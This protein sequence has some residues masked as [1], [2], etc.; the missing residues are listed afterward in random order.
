[1]YQNKRFF[2]ISPI[3]IALVFIIGLYIGNNIN[4][5]SATVQMF[6]SGFQSNKINA[7]LQLIEQEYVDTVDRDE[8]VEKTI[9]KI[10]A[11]LD[12]HS[13]YISAKDFA[14]HNEPLEGN[15]D[16]IG[17]EFNMIK[18]TI[19]IINVISG[20]P[21]EKAGLLAGD[22]IITINDSLFAGKNIST[23]DVIKNLKG[24]KGTK[25]KVGVERAGNPELLFFEIERGTIPLYSVDVAY[26]ATPEI[27]VIKIN[28]FSRTTYQEF[29]EGVEKLIDQGMKKLVVDLRENSG[30]YMDPAIDIIDEFLKEKTLIVYTQ[31]KARPRNSYYATS[32]DLCLNLELAVLIDEWSASASEIFAGAMQDNDRGVIIGRRSFGKGLVQEPKIFKDGSSIRLTIARY[33]TPTGRCIQKPYNN[34]IE[35]YYHD[36]SNRYKHGELLDKDSIQF[37][38][39][40]KYYTPEGKVV[41]GGGGI[42]PDIFIPR[43]TTGFSPYF[44]KIF[45]KNLI[46]EF[47]IDFTDMYRNKMIKLDDYRK[48]AAFIESKGYLQKFIRYAENK[49]VK[50]KQNEFEESKEIISTQIKAYIAR[51]II[52]NDGFYPI[53]QSIDDAMKRAIEE[54]S[55]EDELQKQSY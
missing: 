8:I 29:V 48:I 40:L 46:Y 11:V 24:K 22:R 15:F 4:E 28:K 5:S 17:V 38:D 20:G 44:K 30:G 37:N 42:M 35:S 41:Y 12:P 18:D 45:N 53:I 3:I 39:S 23:E 43:D 10:L 19:L 13:V 36:I 47:A 21:S 1:M 7:V 32:R 16:G 31:G 26:M 34:G 2:I 52:N 55:T 50:Y 25:V 9:P 51:N 54:L 33:Y 6:G 14:R 49:G 27:G